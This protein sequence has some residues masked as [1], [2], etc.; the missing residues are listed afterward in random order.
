MPLN[1]QDIT[2]HRTTDILF[3]IGLIVKGFDALLEVVGGIL[4]LMPTRLAR[5]ILVLSQ[6]ELYRHHAVLSGKLD[7]LA[8]TV[9]E[10]VHIWAAIYLM[11][12]G[13]SKVIL[14]GGIFCGKK[15]GYVGLIGVL[16]FFTA[17]ELIRA[18]S[19]R[20]PVSGVLGVFDLMVVGLIFKEYRYKFGKNTTGNS[21]VPAPAASE[22]V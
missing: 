16:G 22:S 4:L 15:W 14:V 19:A 21:P 7:R 8:E 12:H 17:F 5:Y 10:H 20:E 2:M 18:V 1:R 11:L 6:H 9:L 3:R 13:L